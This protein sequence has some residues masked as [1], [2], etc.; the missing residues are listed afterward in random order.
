MEKITM[1]DYIYALSDKEYLS[2]FITGHLGAEFIIDK[3]ILT[4]ISDNSI[5]DKLRLRF[6]QKI[7]LLKGFNLITDDE[8]SLLKEI[9]KI[10]NSF[11][12]RLEFEIDFDKAFELVQLAH[13]AGIDF[14]DNTI[15]SD[16]EL[17]KTWYDIDGVVNEVIANI[18]THMANK[19]QDIGGE[20]YR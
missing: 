17:S 10:R 11:S 13:K 8:L 2:T 5:Y 15:W 9:N 14:S 18:N 4:K 3:L 7:L 20:V 19:Y 1:S 12:H 6:E 16:K